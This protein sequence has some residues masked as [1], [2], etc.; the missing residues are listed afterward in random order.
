MDYV[1]TINRSWEPIDA[2]TA[3]FDPGKLA[4]VI[5]YA[6]THETSWPYDLEDA[7]PVSPT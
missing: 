3:G 4:A 7:A 1:P 2:A 6:E 5:A